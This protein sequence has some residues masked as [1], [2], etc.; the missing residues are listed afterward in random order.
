[1]TL[2]KALYWIAMIGISLTAVVPFYVS[3]STF[4]PF[5]TGKAYAFRFLVEILFAVWLILAIRDKKYLPQKSYI[6]ISFILFTVIIFFAD[7]FGV[8]QVNSFWSNFERMEGFVTII[9]LLA[10]FTVLISLLRTNKEWSV[11]ANIWVIGSIIMSI[12]GFVQLSGGAIIHQGGVRLDGTLGNATYLAVYMLFN[13]FFAIFLLYKNKNPK[14]RILYGVSIILG[15]ITLY[16]AATRGAILGLIGGILLTSILI[17]IFNKDNL[18]FRKWGIVGG[19]AVVVFVGL[20]I[21]FRNTEFVRGSPVLARFASISLEDTTTLSR[22]ILW[23]IAWEGFKERPILGW[24]QSN[25]N[26][27]FDSNYD[28]RLY[29]QE[30]WFDRAHNIIFDWLVAGGILGLLLYLSIWFFTLKYLWGSKKISNT[31]KSIIT[32]LLAAYFFQNLFVF[33]N[34][35]SYMLFATLIAYINFRAVGPREESIDDSKV[36][37]LSQSLPILVLIALPLVLYFVNAPSYNASSELISGIRLGID[38]QNG[39][40]I[41]ITG[42]VDDNFNSF[43]KAIDRGTFANA[44]V[45]AQFMQT[46]RTVIRATDV[47]DEQKIKFLNEAI[48]QMQK[49][50]LESPLDARYP[51]ILGTF[52]AQSGDFENAKIYLEEAVRLS[53]N[54]QSIMITLSQVYARSDDE[55]TLDYSIETYELEKNNYNAWKNVI[56]NGI[57]IGDNDT[58]NQLIE[59]AFSN[60]ES[61]KVIKL[62]S[63]RVSVDPSNIQLWFALSDAYYRGGDIQNAISVLEEIKN[64][65]P[66]S[67]NIVDDLILSIQKDSNI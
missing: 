21:S 24:G 3:S 34:L 41:T 58:G 63:E 20:F 9:H 8:N 12:Y 1:M 14:L 66:D 61:E 46:A 37:T 16:H 13:I 33:D 18:K 38:S 53:P 5:I 65:F 30:Q 11:L 42:N 6:L 52:L 64:R 60:D 26:V 62:I 45:R 43:I 50:I 32:G 25:F 27:I 40:L 49:Q 55:R 47:P 48:S 57:I 2:N 22:F 10:Y 31:E 19:L 4:F 56:N 39:S 36:T 51:F 15:L 29:N 35:M 23:D 28:T 7:L 54:K 44:E 59:E 17:S 67:K